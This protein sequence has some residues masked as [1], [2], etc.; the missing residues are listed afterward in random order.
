M[1]SEN[2]DQAALDRVYAG[3]AA[4]LSTVRADVNRWLRH[5]GSNDDERSCAVLVV[6][7]MASNAVQATPGSEYHVRMRAI[8][9][10]VVD[11]AVQN[12]CRRGSIPPRTRWSVSDERAVSGRGL[13]IVAA[14]SQDVAVQ[15]T[16]DDVTVRARVRARAS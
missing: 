10:E 2:H 3:D 1:L 15:V 6:S 8:N 16:D 9:D 12:W 4:S 14:L 11:I 5:R 7:E 13:S